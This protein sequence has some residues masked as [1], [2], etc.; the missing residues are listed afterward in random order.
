MASFEERQK[1]YSLNSQKHFY[2]MTLSANEVMLF[3]ALVSTILQK[4]RPEIQQYNWTL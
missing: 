2:F 1:D 4:C 3:P